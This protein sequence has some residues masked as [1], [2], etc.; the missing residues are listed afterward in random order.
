MHRAASYA[1][2]G[3]NMHHYNVQQQQQQ[4]QHR[5]SLSGG[6]QEYHGPPV[7]EQA[8][9]AQ[10]LHR[11]P[12]M[13]QHYYIVEHHNPGIATMNPHPVQAPYQIPHQQ[14]PRQHVEQRA[15]VEIPY[16]APGTI[17]S[18]PSN[19]S[20]ASGRSPSM[21]EGFYAHQPTHTATYALHSASQPEQQQQMAQ[22]PDAVPQH[23]S[24]SQQ[25]IPAVQHQP[26]TPEPYREPEPQPEPEPWYQY[27]PPVEVTTIGQLPPFGSGIYDLYGGP[28]LDFEDPSMPLPSSRV[29]N[30]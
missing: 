3:H 13:P 25:Q 29:E 5:H 1:D 4:L 10:M 9:Q 2:F 18:S 23:M 16:Q 7:P 30:M 27:Q 6:A 11:T 12:S 17:Q 14:I 26:P 21:Q 15:V 20:A 8:H 28:K 22:Y 19:F 24:Q